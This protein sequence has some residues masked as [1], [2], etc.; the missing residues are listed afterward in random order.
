VSFSF[1]APQKIFGQYVVIGDVYYY[2][3]HSAVTFSGSVTLVRYPEHLP[4]QPNSVLYYFAHDPSGTAGSDLGLGQGFANAS[5]S[6]VV[7]NAANMTAQFYFERKAIS[8]SL[9]QMESCNDYL[10]DP[11]VVVH[12]RTAGYGTVTTD[13]TPYNGGNGSGFLNEYVQWTANLA[14]SE[15]QINSNCLCYGSGT[16]AS[17]S[18]EKSFIDYSVLALQCDQRPSVIN[19][20][21][22]ALDALSTSTVTGAATLTINDAR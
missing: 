8:T 1:S 14:L 3:Q 22:R 17:S 19:Q 7:L 2:W 5:A 18:T 13:T 16:S 9:T 10:F 12:G 6:S 20:E 21:T 15:M 4:D 11:G